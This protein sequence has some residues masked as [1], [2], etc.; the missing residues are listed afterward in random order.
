MTDP[1]ELAARVPLPEP[2]IRIGSHRSPSPYWNEDGMGA[3]GEAV[4]ALVIG[5]AVP[6]VSL[7]DLARIYETIPSLPVTAETA[8]AATNALLAFCYLP[9]V[10][11]AIDSQVFAPAPW[12]ELGDHL[13]PLQHAIDVSDGYDAGP[14]NLRIVTM[15]MD[16]AEEM[17]AR[18]RIA[19][20]PA[21]AVD[22][23]MVVRALGLLPAAPQTPNT[24]WEKGYSDAMQLVRQEMPAALTAAL[25]GD[26]E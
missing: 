24:E 10:K 5:E 11:A 6:N 19:A 17:L 26:K 9:A 12:G 8:E 20:P 7:D 2:D 4:A 1:K 25:H 15:R 3:H 18:C 21:P 22:E 14:R 23:A 13:H 16:E